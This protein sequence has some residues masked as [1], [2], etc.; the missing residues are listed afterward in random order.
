MGYVG[1]CIGEEVVEQGDWKAL[2]SNLKV[3]EKTKYNT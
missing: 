3:T 2:P 1:V